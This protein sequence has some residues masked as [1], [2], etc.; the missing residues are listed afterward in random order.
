Q[1]PRQM[2]AHGDGADAGTTAAVRDAA[3]LV[4][5]E[6]A[7]V[8]AE[9][10]QS[11]QPDHGVEVR[12]VDVVLPA[13]V[14]HQRAQLGDL[15]LVD[16]VSGRVG[17]HDAGQPLGVIGDL[18]AQV[19]EIDVAVVAAFHHFDTQSCHRRGGGV[20]A[21]RTGRNQTDVA[22]GLASIVVIA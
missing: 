21:V 22:M 3:G 14:V 20:G 18:R 4:K 19:V 16:A 11:G 17:D 2:R 9:P 1:V 13:R 5:I 10:A 8:A 6:V 15:V 12:A 7:D